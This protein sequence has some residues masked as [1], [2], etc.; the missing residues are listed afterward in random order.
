MIVYEGIDGEPER[1][2][3]ETKG[4]SRPMAGEDGDAEQV[5]A[6]SAELSSVVDETSGANEPTLWV[7][8]GA[9][10]EDQSMGK[11]GPGTQDRRG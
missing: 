9:G 6:R 3:L 11:D 1:G 2:C 4:S 10:V 7:A 5:A 8:E